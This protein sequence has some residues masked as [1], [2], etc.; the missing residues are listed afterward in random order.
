M[1]RVVTAAILVPLV[2]ALLMYAPA[3]VFSLTVAAVLAVAMIEAYG[4]LAAAGA[5][6]LRVLG[7][8]CAVSLAATFDSYSPLQISAAMPLV[9]GIMAITIAAMWSRGNPTEMLDTIQATLLPVLLIGLT[10]AHLI[11][12]R[13]IGDE[14]GRDL[15]FLLGLCVMLGDTAAYYVGSA[16]GRRKMAPRLSP[17]KSWEGAVAALVASVGAAWLAKAWFYPEL[18]LVHALVV[19]ALLGLAGIS[20]D[21]AESL[22]KRAAGVKDSSQLLPGHGGLLDRTD[23]LLFAA[24]VLYYYSTTFLHGAM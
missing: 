1:K 22:L 13:S 18:P 15:I 17:K 19:G 5:T 16:F 21:L 4:I 10:L 8:V 6:P 9:L 14:I 7:L 24:P 20:G 12:L 3:W 23:S 11:G 2:W